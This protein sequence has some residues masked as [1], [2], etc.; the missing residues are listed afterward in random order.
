MSGLRAPHRGGSHA[1]SLTTPTP[2][3][4]VLRPTESSASPRKPAVRCLPALGPLFPHAEMPGAGGWP[5]HITC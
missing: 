5:G 1:P 3:L 2:I 4:G